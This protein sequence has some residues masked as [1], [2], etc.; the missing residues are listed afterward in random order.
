MALLVGMLILVPTP[1]LAR[2][3]DYPA[4]SPDLTVDHASVSSGGSVGVAGVVA[5]RDTVTITVCY[6]GRDCS[7]VDIVTANGSGV[8]S[9]AFRLT[10]PGT[11]TV[12]AVGEPSG[13][14]AVTTVLVLSTD[15]S[16]TDTIGLPR[17]GMSLTPLLGVAGG[18]LLVGLV[19]LLLVAAL[20]RRAR[21]QELASHA[22]SHRVH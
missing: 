19:L 18:A 14:T 4:P 12:T 15:N 21:A 16:D 1:A 6:N 11:A 5:P 10:R 3:A 17:T 20:R 22:H 13:H 7:V 9:V 8:F 2:P